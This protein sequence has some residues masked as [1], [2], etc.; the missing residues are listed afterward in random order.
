MQKNWYIVYARPKCESRVA[1]LLTKKKIENY[2]PLMPKQ[3]K[4]LRKNKLLFEPLFKSYVFVYLEKDRLSQLKQIQGVVNLVYWKG[5]LAEVKN[6]EIAAI[7]EFSYYN[8]E[9]RLERSLVN[10]IEK[11][12]IVN[13]ISYSIEGQ[14][15]SIKNNSVKVN[16]PSLGFNMIASREDKY[17]FEER[18]IRPQKSSYS[19]S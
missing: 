5:E 19:S 3:V 17:Q 14:I 18:V 4:Q 12:K 2:C 13:G 7:K 9:I 8:K 6:E 10:N 11:A 16:L 15:L 1:A